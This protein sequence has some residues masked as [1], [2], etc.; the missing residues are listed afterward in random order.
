MDDTPP[1]RESDDAAE[2]EV[3][4]DCGTGPA[5]ALCVDCAPADWVLV[6]PGDGGALKN[7]QSSSCVASDG[8]FPAH[9][10]HS[11]RWAGGLGW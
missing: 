7:R 8:T 11:E 4:A 10:T 3:E 2:L 6:E 9:M 5:G 1:Y